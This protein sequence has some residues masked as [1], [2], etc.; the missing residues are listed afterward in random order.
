M[1]RPTQSIENDVKVWQYSPSTIYFYFLLVSTGFWMSNH[2]A[3]CSYCQNWNKVGYKLKHKKLNDCVRIPNSLQNK[4]KKQTGHSF[5]FNCRR[6]NC[7]Y[8]REINIIC[9]TIQLWFSNWMV[10]KVL[11]N[12]GLSLRVHLMWSASKWDFE[13]GVL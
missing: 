10:L 4:K 1:H 12:C 11:A 3:E 5:S 13:C 9:R 2:A 6:G 8:P 7:Y